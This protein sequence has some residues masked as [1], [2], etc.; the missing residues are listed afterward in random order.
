MLGWLG[1]YGEGL[2]A[3][4]QTLDKWFVSIVKRSARRQSALQNGT[5]IIFPLCW[6]M[7]AAVL[8]ILAGCGFL[9]FGLISSRPNP[10]DPWYIKPILVS[11]VGALPVVILFLQP[12]RVVV[13]SIGVRQR[14]W[15]GKEKRIPWSDFASVIHDRNDDS[16]IVYGKSASPVTFSPCLV[17]QS[18]FDREVKAFSQTQEIRDDV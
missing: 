9:L 1:C 10:G 3:L 15:W 5:E 14:Y 4:M 11:I 2:A 13:D 18:R 7:R 16:T 17:D 12:G 6:Q 8:F